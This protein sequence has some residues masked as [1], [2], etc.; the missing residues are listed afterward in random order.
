MGPGAAVPP[1]E[2]LAKGSRRR[3]MADH[4]RQILLQADTCTEPG[5]LGA[6]LRRE[7]L[8]SSLLTTWCRQRERGTLQA[9]APKR[10]NPKPTGDPPLKSLDTEENG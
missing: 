9:L 2:V 8:Y 1:P 4:K 3:F 5:Q 7:G 6:L 10:R